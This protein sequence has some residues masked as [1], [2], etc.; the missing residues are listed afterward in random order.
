MKHVILTTVNDDDGTGYA[1]MSDL[2]GNLCFCDNLA[3]EV[4]AGSERCIVHGIGELDAFTE[5][6]D[7]QVKDG[8]RYDINKLLIREYED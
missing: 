2:F 1:L 3:G 7:L 5:A 4:E 6:L 8:R